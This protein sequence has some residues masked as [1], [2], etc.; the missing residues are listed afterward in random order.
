MESTCYGHLWLKLLCCKSDPAK[1]W[2]KAWPNNCSLGS[3][4]GNNTL[5]SLLDLCP[6]LLGLH[7]LGSQIFLKDAPLAL[8]PD[9]GPLVEFWVQ[10]PLLKTHAYIVIALSTTRGIITKNPFTTCK[11]GFV[12]LYQ[13]K[14][15][16]PVTRGI[17]VLFL[18][19]N[20]WW[21]VVLYYML[22]HVISSVFW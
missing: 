18:A 14:C 20:L 11:L 15:T 3:L 5:T 17:R 16:L 22:C 7:N 6:I 2:W 10:L 21:L 8:G 1:E 9:F 13:G 4:V 12:A 19:I